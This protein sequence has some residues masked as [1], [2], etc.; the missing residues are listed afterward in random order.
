MF[1]VSTAD[2]RSYTCDGF[3][4][5]PELFA[6]EEI[7]PLRAAC[8]ADPT[9]RGSVM[10]LAD[11]DG[12][13]QQLTCWTELGDDLLGIFPRIERLV[14]AATALLD[15]EVY[16]WHSKLSLKPPGS[17]GRW[18]WHQDFPYWHKEGCPKPEMLTCTIAVDA[19][20]RENGCLQVLRGTHALGSLDHVPVGRT[21]ACDPERLRRAMEEHE[22][23]ECLMNP[24]D[25]FF[26]HSNLLHASG[27]NAS[28]SPRTLLH[29][30]YNRAT[31]APPVPQRPE[32][33]YRPLA[34]VSDDAIRTKRYRSAFAN[35]PFPRIDPA[36]TNSRYGQEIIGSDDQ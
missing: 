2:I 31:N 15:G 36:K 7:E 35:H 32:R 8:H 29:I 27:P 24:G 10:Q 33:A 34:V 26:F 16:H 3:L 13:A 17:E 18:D 20:T 12:R 25:A 4:R 19:A 28:A 30:T 1:A 14:S 6:P 9:I 11:S 21:T 22:L 5:V 23:A